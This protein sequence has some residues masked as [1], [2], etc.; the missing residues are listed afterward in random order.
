VIHCFFMLELEEALDRILGA[1]PS[2]AAEDLPLSNACGR[3]L[4]KR[5][6]SEV[7]LPIFDNS[8]M[9]GYAVRAADVTGAKPDSPIKL[10]LIG[11]VLAGEVFSGELTSG[12][13][14]RIFTGSPLPPGAEAV[15]MQEDTRVLPEA[16]G[17][18]L[19]LGPAEAGENV[20]RSG[21]DI[22]AGSTL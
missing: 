19:V 5:V 1:V 20:R 13:C 6:V 15:V 3:V 12:T 14:V 10:R 7:N 17:E 8:A 18:V 22:A 4:V 11:R 2:A 21:E 9:D 16:S